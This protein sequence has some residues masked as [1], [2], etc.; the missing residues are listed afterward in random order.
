LNLH[1][2][3]SREKLRT[4]V[5]G[6]GVFGRLHMSK[7]QAIDG[8]DLVAVADPSESARSAAE[9][10][11]GVTAEADWRALRGE[12]DL[13]SVCSPASTHARIVRGFLEAGAHVLVEKPIAT[14]L[15]EADQLIALAAAK[16][17]VLTVG[18]QERFVFAHS[19]LLDIADVPLGIECVRAGPWSGRCTDVSA[20]IDL[21]IHDLDLIHRLVPGDIEDVCASGSTVHGPFADEMTANLQFENGCE[22]RLFASRVANARERSMRLIYPGGVVE[23]DF[24]TRTVRNTTN[25]LLRPLELADPLGEAIGSFVAAVAGGCIPPVRPEE[26][27]RALATALDI[28]EAAVRDVSAPRKVEPPVR[29]ALS[30]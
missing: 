5:I 2:I 1:L 11:Y 28:E 17:R 27:R 12:V 15:E 26:A 19:G 22:V 7:Y 4:A 18:H 20:V 23:F 29:V 25:R 21:M 14:T 16:G 8:V 13:V 24:L 9:L 3:P 30:A 10:K 6:A